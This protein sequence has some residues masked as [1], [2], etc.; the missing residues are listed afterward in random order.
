[1][2]PVI[3]TREQFTALFSNVGR[4][5][6]G[7]YLTEAERQILVALVRHC[8]A[9][10]I[11]EFGIQEGGTARILL[12][13]C[14][15]IRHYVG[16]DLPPGGAPGMASQATEIPSVPGAQVI[17]D[18]RVRLILQDSRTILLRDLPRADFIW[19]DGGHDLETVRR[20]TEL[21]L[22][23]VNHGGCIAWHDYNALPEMA[24]VRATV[25]SVNQR[26]G[27]HAV[28]VAGT[29]TVFALKNEP[30]PYRPNYAPATEPDPLAPIMPRIDTGNGVE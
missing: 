2:A 14:A 22:S 13:H 27:D 24:G 21:A 17:A 16:I 12:D 4:L 19:I 29:W 28:L 6:G 15:S 11:L 30:N 18:P 3:I 20:D 1:M 23:L 26:L 5:P 25:D 10:T 8:R 9:A 7:P